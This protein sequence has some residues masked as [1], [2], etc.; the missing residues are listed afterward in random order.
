MDIRQFKYLIA[1]A[2]HGNFS[3]AAEALNISQSAL[4]QAVAKLEAELSVR[5]FE[6]GRQGAKLTGAGEI[7]LRRARLISAEMGLA[8]SEID[9]FRG[10]TSSRVKVGLEKSL[11]S[12]AVAVA[13]A[14]FAASRPGLTLDVYEGWSPDLAMRLASGQLDFVVSSDSAGTK[15]DDSL[16]AEPLFTKFTSVL[17]SRQHPLMRKPAITVLDLYECL[18]AVT[19]TDFNDVKRLEAA[20]AVAGM[21]LPPKILMTDSDAFRNHLILESKVLGL[22]ALEMVRRELETGELRTIELPGFL[23]KW[24]VYLKSRRASRL[25][26]FAAGLAHNI[27][28]RV[29]EARDQ[30]DADRFSRFPPVQVKLVDT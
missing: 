18:W 17:I 7:L 2:E 15:S 13:L 10:V 21:A 4:T 29:R 14:E 6:R 20:F 1:M 11:V 3:R 5:L 30:G 12:G 24:P 16:L 23:I 8:A 19:M 22:V 26:P 9:A 28:D 27:R 25:Q